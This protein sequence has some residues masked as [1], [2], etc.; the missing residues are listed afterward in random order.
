[1][2]HGLRS[3]RWPWC[4]YMSKLPFLILF[5]NQNIMFNSETSKRLRPPRPPLNPH[6]AKTVA[7]QL[8]YRIPESK[9]P[10]G[11]VDKHQENEI[12][13]SFKFQS[14]FHLSFEI[15][16]QDDWTWNI[17]QGLFWRINKLGSKKEFFDDC[18]RFAHLACG[19]VV[20]PPCKLN[21]YHEVRTIFIILP[22]GWML[23]DPPWLWRF[24]PNWV[25]NR[26]KETQQI[27][28]LERCSPSHRKSPLLSQASTSWES[29]TLNKQPGTRNHFF[30]KRVLQ[31]QQWFC[32][33]KLT[34][35]KEAKQLTISVDLWGFWSPPR[36]GQR[37]ARNARQQC[38]QST[39]GQDAGDDAY[40]HG[41][42]NDG[43]ANDGYAYDESYDGNAYDE[44]N[45]S[46]DESHGCKCYGIQN[47]RT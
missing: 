10:S 37:E 45:E 6:D 47:T 25:L 31:I 43:Y 29:Q 21:R 2:M 27:G 4:E 23:A 38:Q 14:H 40:G 24:G 36:C 5:L 19:F 39:H 11:G 8:C 12:S 17:E 26:E 9:D 35:K 1:M 20:F 46:N 32:N 22:W 34:E 30:V 15:S 18:G 44:S 33:M 16:S 3:W 41:H 42:A 13:G 28:L 7:K